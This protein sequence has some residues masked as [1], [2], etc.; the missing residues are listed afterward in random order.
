MRLC[1]CSALPYAITQLNLGAKLDAL[2]RWARILFKYIL[3]DLKDL[4]KLNMNPIEVLIHVLEFSFI[5]MNIDA[6]CLCILED[7]LQKFFYTIAVYVTI[8][9]YSNNVVKK[10]LGV[11]Q[12]YCMLFVGIYAMLLQKLYGTIK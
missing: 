5:W 3:C 6:S 7:A 9:R 2:N 11:R 12:Y 1:N 8:N 10:T 4:K